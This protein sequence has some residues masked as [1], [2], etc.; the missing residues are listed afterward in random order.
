M[1]LKYR[2]NDSR[3][4][5]CNSN[6]RQIR[7]HTPVTFSRPKRRDTAVFWNRAG[8]SKRGCIWV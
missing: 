8:Y 6:E 1:T 3:R 4:E 7:S 5:I 2:Q